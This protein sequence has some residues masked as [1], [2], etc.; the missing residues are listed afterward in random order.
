MPAMRAGDADGGD[1]MSDSEE[2]YA[3]A[4]RDELEH[5][6]DDLAEDYRMSR[7]NPPEQSMGCLGR[8]ERIQAIT[9]LV[10]PCSPGNVPMPFLLTGMYEKV[11]AEIGITA[12]VPEETLRAARDYVAEQKRYIA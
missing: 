11:H 6:W 5:L 2:T 7:A 4:L 9:R 12:T 1:R 3:Q 8:I 10:G